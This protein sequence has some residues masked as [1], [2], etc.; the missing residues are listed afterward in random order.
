MKYVLHLIIVDKSI[1]TM[2]TCTIGTINML[3]LKRIMLKYYKQASEGDPNIHPQNELYL[4]IKSIG[5]GHAMMVKDVQSYLWIII[6]SK[7]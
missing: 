5:Q 7:N 2:K 3:G 1:K 4:E 6:E